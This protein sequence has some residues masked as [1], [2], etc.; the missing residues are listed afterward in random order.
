MSVQTA[1]NQLGTR[2]VCY[3]YVLF[4]GSLM[5]HRWL[6]FTGDCQSTDLLNK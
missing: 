6:I 1:K 3:K 2:Y 4:Y 5:E